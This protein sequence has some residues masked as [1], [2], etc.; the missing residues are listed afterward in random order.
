MSADKEHEVEFLEK[1]SQNI[2]PEIGTK[3]NTDENMQNSLLTNKHE[4]MLNVSCK[5]PTE[6]TKNTLEEKQQGDISK[7]AEKEPQK[8]LLIKP[9]EI[10]QSDEQKYTQLKKQVSTQKKS[11]SKF[12]SSLF[13]IKR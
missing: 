12:T 1:D 4:V 8:T 9:Q 7:S 10:K 6:I 2:A 3:K 5:N 13:K 11:V